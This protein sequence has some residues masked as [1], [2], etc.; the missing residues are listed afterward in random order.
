MIISAGILRDIIDAVLLEDGCIFA[1][2]GSVGI[3]R[4]NERFHNCNRACAVSTGVDIAGRLLLGI[5]A[6]IFKRICDR[7][8]I[9]DL[10]VLCERRNVDGCLIGDSDAVRRLCNR[11]KRRG[12]PANRRGNGSAARRGTRELE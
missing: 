6:A 5:D 9:F 12:Q 1:V 10:A 7:P 11:L 8:D 4:Y 2:V 3:D